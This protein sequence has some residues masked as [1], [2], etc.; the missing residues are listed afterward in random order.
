M[1]RVQGVPFTVLT[2]IALLLV[3][4]VGLV[5]ASD[6]RPVDGDRATDFHTLG[7]LDRGRNTFRYDTFG[8]QDFWGGTLQIH[9]AI[10]GQRLGGLGPGV[11]PATAL[12]VGLKVDRDALPAS[13]IRDLKVGK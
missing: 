9:K 7:K 10:K 5:S 2:T 1:S 3:L 8:D 6:K 11:S 13:I 12:A 4:R